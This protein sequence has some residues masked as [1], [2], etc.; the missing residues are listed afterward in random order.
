MNLVI[1]FGPHAVGKMTVGQELAKLTGYKLFHNHMTID[2]VADLFDQ[3][4]HLM[5]PLVT[6]FREQIFEVFTQSQNQGLIF[7]FM[8]ALDEPSDAAYLQGIEDRFKATGG[9][10]MY[11]ELCADR[12]VRLDR[13]KTPNRLANK[14][15]KR[16]LERSEA[17]FKKLEAKYRLNSTD[18]EI[19]KEHYLK[20]DNTALDPI[21]VA[22]KIQ[23]HFGLPTYTNQE[24]P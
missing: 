17:M 15:S 18:G 13:N 10:I 5:W 2:V 4:P 20:I 3:D 7:T 14:P 6:S 8:W 24:R 22:K 23:I 11:V 21:S 1:L 16:D 9:K 19:Q 12:D